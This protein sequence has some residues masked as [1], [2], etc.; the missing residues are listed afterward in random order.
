MYFLLHLE[1]LQDP[2]VRFLLVM[3][4]SHRK[5]TTGKECKGMVINDPVIHCTDWDHEDQEKHSN[6]PEDTQ[7]HNPVL[8]MDWGGGGLGVRQRQGFTA[9][10]GGGA[11][12][13]IFRG[14]HG[15]MTPQ[16]ICTRGEG[17]EIPPNSRGSLSPLEAVT[18]M[19]SLSVAGFDL[20]NPSTFTSTPT[21]P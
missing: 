15:T 3:S 10:P 17:I 12:T 1:S 9:G 21:P 16:G 20:A 11:E 7:L 13:Q 19:V 4:W 8:F 5:I 14:R 18:R 6:L 2:S